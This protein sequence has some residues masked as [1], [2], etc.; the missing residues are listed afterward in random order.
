[1][2]EGGCGDALMGIWQRYGMYDVMCSII[3]AKYSPCFIMH[4]GLSA[5]F[6]HFDFKVLEKVERM[7]YRV[8]N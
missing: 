7:S 3:L 1:M 4:I 2:I 8:S 6:D 5:V